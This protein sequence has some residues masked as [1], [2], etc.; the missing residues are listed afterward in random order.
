MKPIARILVGVEF[1]D[2][3]QCALNEASLMAR[4]FGAQVVLL[5]TLPDVTE[6]ER[7]AAAIVSHAERMLE[8]VATDLEEDEVRVRRP[9]LVAVNKAPGDALLAAI[10]EVQPDVTFLGAGTK[11]AMDRVLLG[12][13]AER[14][15]RESPNAVWLTRPGR[16]HGTIQRIVVALDS[17]DPAREALAA[18]AFLARTFVAEL[19]T[20]SVLPTQES[21]DKALREVLGRIDLH[22]INHHIALRH[23]KP[24]VKIVEAVSELNADLLI[25]GT[26]GR[27]GVARLLHGN[28][29]EKVL[30]QVPCSMLVVPAATGSA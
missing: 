8:K 3:G 27:K 25:L 10:A 19:H 13:T 15:V 21:G 1:T 5:H 17:S 26:A 18:A 16:D 2:A 23:G 4:L 6:G 12:S 28:T 20:L 9:F 14:I 22:G 7:D 11:T 24:A 30:R 29:A